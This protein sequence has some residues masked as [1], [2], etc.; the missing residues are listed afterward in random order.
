M[1]DWENIEVQ[2]KIEERRGITIYNDTNQSLVIVAVPMIDRIDIAMQCLCDAIDHDV[3]DYMYFQNGDADKVMETLRERY[4]KLEDAISALR[5]KK[6][7][8]AD[9]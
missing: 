2:P 1:S 7:V 5:G 6:N 3:E 8:F 9:S 4:Q